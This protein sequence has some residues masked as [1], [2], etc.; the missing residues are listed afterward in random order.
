MCD[1]AA[2]G[3]EE[4]CQAERDSAGCDLCIKFAEGCYN[5]KE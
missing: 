1:G 5:V 2:I 3:G 4:D